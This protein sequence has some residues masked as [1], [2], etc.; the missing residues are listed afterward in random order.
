MSSSE[1]LTWVSSRSIGCP[2]RACAVA[3][4]DRS[5]RTSVGTWI[6]GEIS[7]AEL[8]LHAVVPAVERVGEDGVVAVRRH[9]AR[10]QV[11]R[12]AGAPGAYERTRL[13]VDDQ[14]VQRPGAAVADDD[15][16]RLV[17]VVRQLGLDAQSRPGPP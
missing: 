17:G 1:R 14:L 7:V 11:R 10:V 8:D 3:A 9:R 5:T 15:R 2:A 6:T 12:G 4:S 16:D 13:A